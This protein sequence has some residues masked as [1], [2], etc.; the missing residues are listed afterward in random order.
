MISTIGFCIGFRMPCPFLLK[1]TVHKGILLLGFADHEK[2]VQNYFPW[3]VSPPRIP[4][5]NEG[6]GRDFIHFL[7]N[8]QQ[9]GP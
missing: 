9:P 1:L 7:S 5:A 6:L 8:F 3:V 4:V 2:Q